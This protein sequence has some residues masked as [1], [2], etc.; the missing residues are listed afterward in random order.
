MQDF[1]FSRRLTNFQVQ[2][3]HSLWRLTTVFRLPWTKSKKQQSW[4]LQAPYAPGHQSSVTAS[5]ASSLSEAGTIRLMKKRCSFRLLRTIVLAPQL[6]G[7]PLFSFVFSLAALL[8]GSF[9]WHIIV[10]IIYCTDKQEHILNPAAIFAMCCFPVP[11]QSRVCV[12]DMSDL[13]NFC[14]IPIN[15]M[16]LNLAPI[17]NS[18]QLGLFS[19]RST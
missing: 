1:D 10:I 13:K 18:K 7:S 15:P 12:T 8:A 3:F 17:Q 2:T 9:R 6:F 16:Q 14:I 11:Y 5:P 4:R 19:L